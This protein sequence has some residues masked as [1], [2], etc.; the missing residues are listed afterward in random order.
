MST[1]RNGRTLY[2][3]ISSGSIS[4]ACLLGAARVA[5]AQPSM[6]EAPA[7][8]GRMAGHEGHEGGEAG[9]PEVDPST[10]FNFFNFSY[11]GKDEWGGAL[12]DGVMH[13]DASGVTEHEEE[14]MSPP[15]V[16]ML[17]NFGIL[18]L[19]LG[20]YGRPAAQKLAAD[21]HDQIKT[22]LDD[23]AK[24]RK[25]AADK[26]A[27]YEA[28]IKNLDAE[29]QKLVDGIKADAEADKARILANTEAQAA[30]MKRDAELRI[31]A[32]IETA[33]AMLTKEVAVAATTA[34]TTLLRQK[35]TADDQTKLVSTFISGIPTSKEARP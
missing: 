16:L 22:A 15:F 2:A 3:F 21:R 29:V 7:A 1:R 20:K 25:D 14:A 13:D 9:E 23:A 18:L 34:A 30:Q 5:S 11:K 6:G 31:A 17:L 28:R 33:R 27:E 32:E 24:L 19:I 10:H 4:L 12:G 35:T 8:E 26:L